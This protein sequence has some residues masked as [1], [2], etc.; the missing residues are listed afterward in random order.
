M[1]DVSEGLGDAFTDVEAHLG[2][3]RF[4]DCTHQREPGCAVRAAIDAGE[5]DP[6]RWESFQKL[7][8]ESMDR[9]EMLRRKKE[10]SKGVAKF[11]R[12]RNKEVW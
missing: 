11:T 7:D 10:W 3:C 5:L 9:E 1:W 4:S 12:N 6:V 8:Q 2:K